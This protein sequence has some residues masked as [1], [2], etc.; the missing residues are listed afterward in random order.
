MDYIEKAKLHVLAQVH[1]VIPQVHIVIP[2]AL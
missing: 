1:T 2:E